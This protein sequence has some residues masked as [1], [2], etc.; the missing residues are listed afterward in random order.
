MRAREASPRS[1]TYSEQWGGSAQSLDPGYGMQSATS[2]SSQIDDEKFFGRRQQWNQSAH[3]NTGQPAWGRY[4]RED[5]LNVNLVYV[6][7]CS[8][9]PPL[10]R[11]ARCPH[12]AHNHSRCTPLRD[13]RRKCIRSG[14]PSHQAHMT[15]P[16]S[17]GT[18]TIRLH[19][20]A[21]R[22]SRRDRGRARAT[23]ARAGMAASFPHT[24]L[25]ATRWRMGCEPCRPPVEGTMAALARK[26]LSEVA[27]L[28]D[29]DGNGDVDSGK[30]HE[31]MRRT[32]ACM[33][34]AG[35]G[36]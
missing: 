34:S 28:R 29:G 16:A 14:S 4:G 2:Y 5:R 12:P 19:R 9:L 22:H 21:R 6:R 8:T 15:Q 3:L 11:A 26:A 35:Y 10:P 24:R 36:K 23:L 7:R 18:C 1:V 32:V 17:D 30:A 13:R 31:C 25:T 33:H 20:R 27:R